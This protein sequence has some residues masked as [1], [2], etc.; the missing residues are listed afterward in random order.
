MSKPGGCFFSPA[1]H[2]LGG[3]IKES[4]LPGGKGGGRGENSTPGGRTKQRMVLEPTCSWLVREKNGFEKLLES[5]HTTQRQ[6]NS[7]CVP[8]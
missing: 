7:G 2:L 8:T 4:M 6:R 5:L 3:E 1:Y